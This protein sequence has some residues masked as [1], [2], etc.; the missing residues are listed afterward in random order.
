MPADKSGRL[1]RPYSYSLYAV[2]EN[3]SNEITRRNK[4]S[5]FKVDK[6]PRRRV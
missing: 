6:D 2:E 5:F 1:Y 4:I 3:C